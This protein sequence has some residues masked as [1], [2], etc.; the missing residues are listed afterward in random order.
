MTGV[1]TCALPILALRMPPIN[2]KA[3][4]SAQAFMARVAK[5]E[6]MQCPCCKANALKV[7]ATLAGRQ[8]PVPGI[9]M[10]GQP[11]GPP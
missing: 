1:Q 2:P 8:L 4:E 9:V 6:V 3:A 10:S 7:E 5:L 11:R